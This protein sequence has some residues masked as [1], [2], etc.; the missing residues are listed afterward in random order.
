[1]NS[2]E[3]RPQQLISDAAHLGK[4]HFYFLPPMVGNPATSGVFDPTLAPR[5]E[6]CVL[7]GTACAGVLTTFSP[8]TGSE[9][10]RLSDGH[11]IVNWHT[12][13]FDLTPEETYRIRVL[14]QDVE[15]GFA[16]VDLVSSGRELR[17]VNT[18]EYIP[19]L[20]GRTLPIKF[21]VEEGFLARIVVTPNPAS[22]VVTMTQQFEAAATDLHGNALPA[23]FTWSSGD[24]TIAT[25]DQNG[26]ARTAR[27]RSTRKLPGPPAAPSSTS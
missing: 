23:T 19:L 6:V 27:C 22:T 4:P 26:L 8:G 16:D 18:N 24:G 15:L 2:D 3:I 11:Y 1:V 10:V 14:V 5:V 9:S 13:R 12:D 7:A 21:R 20:D 17:N 25:V